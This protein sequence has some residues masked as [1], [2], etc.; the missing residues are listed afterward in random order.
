MTLIVI[1]SCPL[2]IYIILMLLGEIN[3][4]YCDES[5]YNIEYLNNKFYS[6]CHGFK[7]YYYTENIVQLILTIIIE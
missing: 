1:I 6:K 2:I 4:C 3:K 7:T 5:I